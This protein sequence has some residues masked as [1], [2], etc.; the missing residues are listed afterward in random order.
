MCDSLLVLE[1]YTLLVF[2][3]CTLVVLEWPSGA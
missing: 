3:R 2:E 1:W